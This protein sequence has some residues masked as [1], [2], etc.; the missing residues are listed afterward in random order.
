MEMAVRTEMQIRNRPCQSGRMFCTNYD[1]F[2][3]LP[4]RPSALL[5]P[6]LLLPPRP[7]TPT[8]VRRF[9]S[10]D[11]LIGKVGWVVVVVVVVVMG[12][13]SYVW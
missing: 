5:P 10:I 4:H 3:P 1:F 13:E 11:G 2:Q 7:R 8:L 9:L 6:L 12:C